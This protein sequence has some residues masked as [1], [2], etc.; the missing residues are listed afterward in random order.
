MMMIFYFE[1]IYCHKLNIL[2]IELK[3]KNTGRN[4]RSENSFTHAQNI[5]IF[6]YVYIKKKPAT[7][8]KMEKKEKKRQN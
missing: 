8:N 6:I 4:I 7:K 3:K 1:F 2:P 5:C